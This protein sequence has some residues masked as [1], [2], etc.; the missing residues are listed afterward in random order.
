MFE[1]FTK[2]ISQVA[3][4]VGGKEIFSEKGKEH[5]QALSEQIGAKIAALQASNEGEKASVVL[6]S[7]SSSSVVSA[8]ISAQEQQEALNILLK[9]KALIDKLAALSSW[10]LMALGALEPVAI[11]PEKPIADL[12][13][14]ELVQDLLLNR[15][16][17]WDIK[18]KLLHHSL[19]SLFDA[20]A[21][22]EDN[23]FSDAGMGI[24]YTIG[25]VEKI[26]AV[27]IILSS[28]L[29]FYAMAQSYAGVS[30]CQYHPLVGQKIFPTF[31]NELYNLQDA[32]LANFRKAQTPQEQ[33]Q[34]LNQYKKDY[35][36]RMMAFL[37]VVS[38]LPGEDIFL[39]TR[40]TTFKQDSVM[41]FRPQGGILRG[42]LTTELSLNEELAARCPDLMKNTPPLM[43]VYNHIENGLEQD[44]VRARR[45]ELFSMVE[46]ALIKPFEDYIAKNKNAKGLAQ[47]KANLL[48]RFLNEVIYNKSEFLINK[49]GNW[50]TVDNY[51]KGELYVCAEIATKLLVELIAALKAHDQICKAANRGVGRTGILLA[52]AIAATAK[53][54]EI[55]Y[56]RCLD[57]AFV[58]DLST[59]RQALSAKFCSFAAEPTTSFSSS[60]AATSEGKEKE[61]EDV[62]PEQGSESP[63]ASF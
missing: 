47:E 52:N 17:Y 60:S 56:D 24:L 21:K 9:V 27:G 34:L 23:D 10:D 54:L 42:L 32:F 20:L 46:G 48:Q 18:N 1:K 49:D 3:G 38:Q 59:Y 2:T 39:E 11:N 51:T 62:M 35:Q 50:R 30:D 43:T 16:I 61:A 22:L 5:L 15:D 19:A 7:S 55:P 45:R 53:Y 40:N 28:L 33:E 41:S 29:P 58:R 6:P 26:H 14:E 36:D 63:S 25:G 4:V 37:D 44:T 12:T 57:D 8:G 13:L 31:R